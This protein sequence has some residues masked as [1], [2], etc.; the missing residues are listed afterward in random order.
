[1]SAAEALKLIE[2]AAVEEWLELDLSGL[3]LDILPSEIG[4]L[5]KLN[6]RTRRIKK[7]EQN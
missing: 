5:E 1:M 6:S 7:G 3:N 2:Q 4:K